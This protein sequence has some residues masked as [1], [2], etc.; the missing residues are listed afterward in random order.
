MR[1]SSE[2]AATGAEGKK[3]RARLGARALC[4]RSELI[5]T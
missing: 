4:Q 1:F 2:V 5:M 3:K